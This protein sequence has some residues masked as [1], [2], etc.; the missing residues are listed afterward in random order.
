MMIERVRWVVPGGK[1]GDCGMVTEFLSNLL[2]ARVGKEQ[3]AASRRDQEFRNE[4]DPRQAG[5]P[6]ACCHQPFLSV[7]FI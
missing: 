5:F 2:C 6:A 4:L 3:S 7:A 1:A